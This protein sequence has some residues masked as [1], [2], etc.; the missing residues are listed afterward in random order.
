MKKL[1]EKRVEDVEVGDLLIDNCEITAIKRFENGNYGFTL[2]TSGSHEAIQVTCAKTIKVQRDH[3]I[4]ELVAEL[5]HWSSVRGVAGFGVTIGV[6][7]DQWW[8]GVGTNM[9]KGETIAKALKA[10]IEMVRP[11]HCKEC[12]SRVFDLLVEGFGRCK[13]CHYDKQNENEEANDET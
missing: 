6:K 12:G 2:A 11:E 8:C 7:S 10:C 5:Q 3:T 13:R 4:E 1:V 9:G